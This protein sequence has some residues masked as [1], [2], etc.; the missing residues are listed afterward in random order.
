MTT[1]PEG[2]TLT[3]ALAWI[4]EHCVI[5]DGFRKGAPFRLYDFQLKYLSEFYR[6]RSTAKWVPDNPVKAP[7]FVYRR[8]MLIAPQKNGKGPLSAAHICLESVGPALFAGWAQLGDAYVCAENGCGCGWVYDYEPGEPMGMPWPNALI[9]VTAVSIEQTQNIYRSL[10]PMISEGPL[11]SI[12]P[13]TGEEFIRLP[14][15]G[16]VETVTSSAQ[17]RLGALVTFCPQDEVGL[18]TPTNKMT[19]VADTQWRGLAGMGGRASITSNAWDP[20]ERSVAQQVYESTAPDVYRQMTQAP[21]SLSYRNKVERRKIH[22]I[23]Y[24]EA[25]TENGG[26]V[27]LDAIEAEVA[28]LMERDPG[29]AARFYGNLVVYGHGAWLPDGLWDK[30]ATFREIPSGTQVCLG[31]DGS[32][33]SD[34]SAIRAE[35]IDGWSFTPSYGPDFKSTIWNP[36]N[37][38]GRIPRHEVHA[39]VEQI[40]R[41]YK[42]KRFYCDPRDWASE[43]EAWSLAYPDVDVVAWSNV[44]IPKTHFALERFVTDLNEGNLTHDG[45][46]LTTTH[47]M[48]ARKVAKAGDRYILDKPTPQQKID[49]AM[50]SV[51]AHEARADAIAK[52]WGVPEP[53]YRIARGRNRN[54]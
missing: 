45:C 38:G 27:D 11:S 44:N 18:W 54:G 48:N 20:A 24:G 2:K 6:V 39:A 12:I 46:P 22:R 37:F 51:L 34:H 10:R 47:V 26:H 40:M 5:P 29:Q 13:H 33:T 30:T 52:G 53:R 32:S 4:E 31:F 3:V 9:Q 21:K 14:G 7:A 50:A 36:E 35:T 42:V 43:V 17:S 49:A 23:V 15:G 16:R 19:K 41:T 8:G 28:E 25:L 1:A